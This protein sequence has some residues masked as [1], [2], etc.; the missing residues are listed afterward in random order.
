[1]I[2]I[3]EFNAFGWK[4]RFKAFKIFM[5]TARATIQGQQANGRDYFLFFSS[6]TCMG[7]LGVSIVT[8]FTFPF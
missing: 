6:T 8:I 5:G 3:N 2:V 4:E 7:P 1:L